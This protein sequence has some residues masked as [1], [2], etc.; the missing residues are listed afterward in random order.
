MCV[1]G[2]AFW[3]CATLRRSST[4]VKD[5][6]FFNAFAN[7]GI[8]FIHTLLDAVLLPQRVVQPWSKWS[9]E[10]F[11]LKFQGLLD[12]LLDSLTLAQASWFA[13]LSSHTISWLPFGTRR[14][15]DL[16]AVGGQAVSHCQGARLRPWDA[17]DSS[18]VLIPSVSSLTSPQNHTWTAL[19][20][21][22]CNVNHSFLLF[23]LSPVV[24]R[25]SMVFALPPQSQ[26]NHY[27]ASP[28]EAQWS[29]RA[30]VPIAILIYY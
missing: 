12:S 23:N 2:R 13:Q 16:P 30:P 10:F 3:K 4:D 25:D 14:G 19:R 1:C 18:T 5:L 15:Q 24:S 7:H 29:T 8:L 21:S 20:Q 27:C 6:L 26:W 28:A 11:Q 17:L 22:L 9:R